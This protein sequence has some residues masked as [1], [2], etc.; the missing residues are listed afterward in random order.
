MRAAHGSRG[1]KSHFPSFISLL[2]SIL[3]LAYPTTLF[4]LAKYFV[5][6]NVPFQD[7]K[8]SLILRLLVL[9]PKI[10][11][12]VCIWIIQSHDNAFHI[13]KRKLSSLSVPCTHHKKFT[14]KLSSK[15]ILFILSV[16][17]ANKFFNS[18]INH[19]VFLNLK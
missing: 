4:I 11:P 18:D 19:K 12:E 9:W 10:F 17:N 8:L 15:I 3:W 1:Q 16:S 6:F 14:Q 13:L 7:Q 2:H 5:Q